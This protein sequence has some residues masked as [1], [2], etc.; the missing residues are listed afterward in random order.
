MYRQG[1]AASSSKLIT[2]ESLRMPV[3][4]PTPRL[5]EVPFKI[6]ICGV[7]SSDDVVACSDAGA[8]CIGLNFYPPSVRSLDPNSPETSS[9]NDTAR[10]HGLYRVGLFVNQTPDQVDRIAKSLSLDAIQFHGDEPRAE[11]VRVLEAGFAVVRAIRLPTSPITPAQ[12]QTQLEPLS[13]L[14]ITFLLDADVGS[15]YGGGGK[16]LHW[17][18][19]AAWAAVEAS[20]LKGG[21][22]LAGGLDPSCV[23][24]AIQLSGASSVDVASGVESR[25]GE[26]SPELIQRFVTASR[27]GGVDETS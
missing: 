12:I 23:S 21:W 11:I 1:A 3:S 4:H 14:P 5:R 17:P 13:D 19:I 24:Q 8:D 20:K 9:L 27:L 6:K 2:I 22:V 7:R 15:A 10:Q 16:Q 26:K 25:R 18:S